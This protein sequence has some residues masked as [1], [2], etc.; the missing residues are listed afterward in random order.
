MGKGVLLAFFAVGFFSTSAIFVRLAAP[1]SPYEITFWRMLFAAATVGIG[2]L[3]TRRTAGKLP[4]ERRYLLFGLIAA[5]HFLLFVTSL[6]FTSIAHALSI[7]YLAPVFIAAA[8]WRWLGEKLTAR[9][10]IGVAIALAGIAILVGLEPRLTSR[11]LLGDALALLSAVT[12]AAYSLAG[13]SERGRHG[14]LPYALAVY[15]LA[16]LWLA[17][18][19]AVG[20]ASRPGGAA[21]YTLPRVLALLGSGILPL[22]LGHTLYNASVRRIP[23]TYANLIASQEVTGGV[24]LGL[25]L[26]GEA[27]SLNTIAGAAVAIIGIVLVLL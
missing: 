8:S 3:F 15:S 27:P 5:L 25:I 21:A 11:M 7:T 10:V 9:Q 19:L 2:V 12:Y 17:P 26:L 23:A 16:A 20:F 18:A 14:L 24:A 4:R 13:R 1:I 6:S 22:G